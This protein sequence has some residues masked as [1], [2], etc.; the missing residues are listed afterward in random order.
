MV[1]P[2]GRRRRLP[3][4]RAPAPTPRLRRARACSAPSDEAQRGDGQRRR[5]RPRTSRPAP[6]RR[7]CPDDRRDPGRR[8]RRPTATVAPAPTTAPAPAP[9]ATPEPLAAAP[10]PAH[11]RHR[12]ARRHDGT[13]RLTH[14]ADRA[15]D[16][17]ALRGLPG[18][19]SPSARPA[20]PGSASS[21]PTR[22]KQAAATQQEADARSCPPA[23]ARSP[24]ATGIE[25]AVSQPATT[26]AATPYLVKD[27]A[28]GR[29]AAR[30]PAR[31]ARGR[32]PAPARA[33][34]HRLRLPRPPRARRSRAR[35]VQ[36]HEDRGAR[37]HPRVTPRLPA[38]LA[39]LAA[40]RHRRHR[41]PGPVRASSTRWTG[42]CSG[43]DGERRLS[44]T[45][46]ARRSSCARSSRPSPARTSR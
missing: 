39:G 12:H 42:C 27:P 43:A 38:R 29:R 33:P 45:R 23:A 35:K 9:T 34:R 18:A 32:A 25:L 28:E 44:R 37:V 7:S 13:G 8:R 40:A 21:R 36:A 15:P 6:S 11:R 30:R 17:P 24:T 19:C 41:Q 4:A 14:E 46:S 2:A 31:Q 3:H 16:R 20:P 5:T 10:P 26:I 1:A 22:C